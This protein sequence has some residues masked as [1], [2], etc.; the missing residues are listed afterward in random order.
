MMMVQV[1]TLEKIRQKVLALN[2]ITPDKKFLTS[3]EIYDLIFIPGFSTAM[4]VTD[5]SGR[6]VGM[7]VVNRKI[8]DIR[9][10]VEVDS[11]VGVGTTITIKLPL[12]AFNY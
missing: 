11:E 10:E 8:A 7:D 2:L 12:N 3:K 6:G 1:L 5:V 9:G 4:K